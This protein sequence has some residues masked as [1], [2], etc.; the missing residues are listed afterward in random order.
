MN[1]QCVKFLISM[2]YPLLSIQ[3]AE[4]KVGR[5]LIHLCALNALSLCLRS[6]PSIVHV[7]FCFKHWLVHWSIGWKLEEGVYARQMEYK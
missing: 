7:F 6:L 5:A 2:D 4:W 1:E 3:N